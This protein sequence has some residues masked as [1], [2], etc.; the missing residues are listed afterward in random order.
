M[1]RCFADLHE[2]LCSYAA[3]HAA[4]LKEESALTG[5]HLATGLRTVLDSLLMILWMEQ[6]SALQSD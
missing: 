1:R 5:A 2:S 4:L 3:S 6:V